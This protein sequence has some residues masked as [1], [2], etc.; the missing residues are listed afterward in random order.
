MAR[1]SCQTLG[2]MHTEATPLF[3]EYD[4]RDSCVLETRF[5][6][7]GVYVIVEAYRR[8]ASQSVHVEVF[9]P[10]HRGLV[11]LDEGDMPSWLGAECFRTNHLVYGVING[12]WFANL[13]SESGLLAIASAT[14]REWLVVTANECV[15]VFSEV[16]PI[17][18]ELSA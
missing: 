12:G 11:L 6:V 13:S 3:D 9:F 8:G 15:S 17:V 2:R 7:V 4:R 1:P 16:E 10:Q 14:S 5:S 18:R